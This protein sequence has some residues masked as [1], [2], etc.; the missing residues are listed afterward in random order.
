M[1]RLCEH[2]EKYMFVFVFFPSAI[3]IQFIE[4]HY[5]NSTPTFHHMVKIFMT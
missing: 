3:L 1:S 5:C 4:M 2:E